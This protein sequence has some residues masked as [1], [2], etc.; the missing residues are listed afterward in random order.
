MNGINELQKN[1]AEFGTQMMSKLKLYEAADDSGTNAYQQHHHHHHHHKYAPLEHL[2]NR[3]VPMFKQLNEAEVARAMISRYWRDLY[4][5]A[6]CDVVIVG[7]GSAGLSC[8]Y[9]LATRHPHLSIAI[10]EA[11]VAPGGGA[12][13]GGQLMSAMVVDK[14]MEPFLDELEVPYEEGGPN[15]VV[16]PH[17]ALFTATLLAKVL[18]QPNVKLFNATA[19]EDL[20]IKRQ[21]QSETGEG[22]GKSVQQQQH[23]VGVVT[24]WTLV[25][26]NHHSQSCMDPSTVMAKVVISAT[27]HDG[28]MGA[29]CVKRLESMK[30]VPKL[31]GM[32]AL[33]MTRAEAAVVEN[34]R[35]VVPGLIIAGMELAELDGA[36]RMGPIFGGMMASGIKAAQLAAKKLN[37]V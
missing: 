27:G 12:W 21:Q 23:V 28:P 24:N 1:A 15:F 19:V 29:F 17:A 2:L 5:R 32:G 26:L 10:I 25:A 18:A 35:E 13:L 6:E 36:S 22:P 3:G 20:I 4:E 16:V 37:L 14:E 30:M 11:N 7:A 9:C 34:T 31:C 8:A 33:D